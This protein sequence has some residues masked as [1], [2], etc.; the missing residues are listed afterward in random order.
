MLCTAVKGKDNHRLNCGCMQ[1]A[2]EY[3]KGF[4]NAAAKESHSVEIP[5]VMAALQS[6]GFLWDSEADAQLMSSFA[7]G[8]EALREQSEELIYVSQA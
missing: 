1:A 2:D 7:P 6:G 3:L 4:L 8:H 5:D